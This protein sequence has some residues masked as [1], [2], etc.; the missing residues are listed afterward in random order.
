M[1]ITREDLI[2]AKRI[3]ELRKKHG[4]TQTS[5]SQIVGIDQSDLS[6]LER[7]LR[8]GNFHIAFAA[9]K[10]F[11]TSVDY[12]LGLTDERKPYPEATND[13]LAETEA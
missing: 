1:A 7:G 6:K 5:F 12:L 10:L 4:Y 8:Q 3:K 2:F 9:A 11:E 13:P